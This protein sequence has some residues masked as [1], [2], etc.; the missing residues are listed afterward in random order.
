MKDLNTDFTQMS[1]FSSTHPHTLTRAHRTYSNASI[2]SGQGSVGP[3]NNSLSLQQQQQQQFGIN[4]LQTPRDYP[5]YMSSNKGSPAPPNNNTNNL[6]ASLSQSVSR[7]T[8]ARIQ[9]NDYGY[10]NRYGKIM[11]EGKILFFFKFFF[12]FFEN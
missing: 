5:Y 6:N 3:S 12:F 2:N 8:A 1:L 4:K 11:H 7:N 9:T 10:I